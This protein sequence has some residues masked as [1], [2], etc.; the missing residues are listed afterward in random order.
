VLV[1][2][3][4]CC[5][6]REFDASQA[7][8]FGVRECPRGRKHERALLAAVLAERLDSVKMLLESGVDPRAQGCIDVARYHG[9]TMILA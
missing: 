3:D 5:K 6:H 8:E 9:H 2:V 7:Y 1:H 4:S